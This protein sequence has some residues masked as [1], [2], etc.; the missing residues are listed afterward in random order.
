MLPQLGKAAPVRCGV[1]VAGEAAHSEL[2]QD[3]N[4]QG[5][6]PRAA[7]E[8]LEDL[9]EAVA[10]CN[11]KALSGRGMLA[12]KH[13]FI[14]QVLQPCIAPPSSE[15]AADWSKVRYFGCFQQFIYA[16]AEM[17]DKPF[18][19]IVSSIHVYS[20]HCKE[21]Q[22]ISVESLRYKLGNWKSTQGTVA[23]RSFHAESIDQAT[24]MKKVPT[25]CR[26]GIR[27]KLKSLK[28]NAAF[29]TQ[30]LFAPCIGGVKIDFADHVLQNLVA[31]HRR[32]KTF[33][34]WISKNFWKYLVLQM[35]SKLHCSISVGFFCLNLYKHTVC[36]Y[37]LSAFVLFRERLSV[38]T[39]G[40]VFWP[41]LVKY[42]T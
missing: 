42:C 11:G 22:N 31:N 1:G 7:V 5:P 9:A 10:V 6:R 2:R 14:R 40:P 12:K 4:R 24:R 41:D 35:F 8:L 28:A 36:I 16:A 32:L 18:M 39:D 25:S 37:T 23:S 27:A 20:H 3:V 19:A 17:A 30:F 38:K 34:F 15:E 33:V 29:S 13:G 21:A 26:N